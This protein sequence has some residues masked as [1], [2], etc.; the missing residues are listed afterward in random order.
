MI[1]I[2]I[3]AVPNQ[4]FSIILEGRSYVIGLRT[5]NGQTSVSIV[6]D[7]V[8]V[9]TNLRAASGAAIIPAKYQEN[10]N[11]TF[12]TANFQLP[13]YTQFNLTQNFVYFTADE[14]QVYRLPAIP[15][16]PLA[17]FNPIAAPPLRYR[18]QGY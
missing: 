14:L 8:P 10:G 5:T 9:I 11:F 13:D 12:L 17:S 2:P 6:R 3:L 15:P 4:E 7:T 16:I 18:P 1:Q